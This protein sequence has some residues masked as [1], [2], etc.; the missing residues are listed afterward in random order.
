VAYQ[1]VT[2]K[3]RTVL[4]AAGCKWKSIKISFNAVLPS[5]QV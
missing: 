2:G 5:E 4:R 1:V 3:M